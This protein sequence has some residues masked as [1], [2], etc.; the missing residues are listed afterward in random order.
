MYQKLISVIVPC[1]NEQPV[2]P[3]Y[4]EKMDV[5]MDNFCQQYPEMKFEILMVNDGSRDGTLDI[6]RKIAAENPTTYRYL[7]FSRNFGK[8]AALYAGLQNAKGDFVTVMDADLQDPPELLFQMYAGITQ[9]GY[10]CV[11]VRRTTREGEPKV[12]S[13]FA[14]LFYKLI[15]KA[16]DTEIVNGARDYRLMT[17]QMVNAIL[18]MSERNRFSKGL[19]SW[20]GFK[21]KWL[22]YKNIERA[23]GTTSWSFWKLFKYSIDGF[24]GFTTAPLCYSFVAACLSWVLAIVFFI[25]GC[26]QGMFGVNWLITSAI[27]FAAGLIL[28]GMGITALY[29]SKM[30]TE[31]KSRPI[32]I[33]AERS[34]AE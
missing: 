8:E 11:G 31:I 21:T 25:I 29:I 34:D 7:S 18:E 2:L 19:F 5:L 27:F 9:E 16:S 30:Y 17:R 23:A 33:I 28:I 3:L 6:M 20:V 13:W 14:N 1:Y 26:C 10:D 15:N 22:E 24:L 12:R 32:Y 4:K